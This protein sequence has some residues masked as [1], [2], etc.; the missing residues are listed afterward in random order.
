[1]LGA[2]SGHGQ[3]PRSIEVE[4]THKLEDAVCPP[5][6]I[7]H[8]NFIVGDPGIGKSQMLQLCAKLFP[9]GIFANRGTLTLH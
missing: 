1:M 2:R 9:T 3:V 6:I 7:A 8:W 4:L 5:T